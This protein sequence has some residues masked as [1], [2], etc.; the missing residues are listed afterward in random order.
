[1]TDQRKLAAVMFTDIV[2]YTALMSKDERQALKILQ[3]NRDLQKSLAE[4]HN[5]EFLKEMGD[6]TLLCFQSALDAVRCAMEIQKSVQD[7]SDLN[8]RIGIHLGDIVFKEGDVF[9]DGVNVASRIERLAEAGCICISEEV[10]R[11]VRNQPEIK[12]QYIGKR[13]LKNVKI[14]VKIYTI[15]GKGISVT[16]KKVVK[17]TQKRNSV[18]IAIGIIFIV[19]PLLILVYTISKRPDKR[20]KSI[21]VLPFEIKSDDPETEYLGEGIAIGVCNRL[22]Q[23]SD[24]EKV[25]SSSTLRNYKGKNVDAK[26]VAKEVKVKAVLFGDIILL[27]NNMAINVELKD[28]EDNSTLWGRRYTRSN[29]SGFEIEALLAKEIVDNLGFKL[30]GEDQHRLTRI[31]SDNMEIY[32]LYLRGCFFSNKHT[33]T[34]FMEGIEYFK[35]A[36]RLDSTYAPAFVGLAHAYKELARL[37]YISRNEAYQKAKAAIMRALEIDETLGEAHAT[38]GSILINFDW[39]LEK[40]EQEFQRALQLSPGSSI[41]HLLYSQYLMWIGQYDEAINH[42]KKAVDLDPLSSINS[43][44]LAGHYFYARRYDESIE[45]LRNNLKMNP[46]FIWSYNYLAYNYELKGMVENAAACAD[47]ALILW[48][49]TDDPI[50]L[51]TLG[52]VYAKTGRIKKARLSLEKLQEVSQKQSIDPMMFVHIYNGLGNRDKAFEYLQKAYEIRSGT[53]I[54]LN[55]YSKNQLRDIGSDDRYKTLLKK[56]GFKGY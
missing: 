38:L 16:T 15:I 30:S 4:K 31:H 51:G 33:E 10:Y 32:N 42:C 26:A 6:G 44:W 35:R 39:D 5:G 49:D 55:A 53:F 40:P 3:K 50:A 28:A 54:Y 19:I 21:A 1:M 13:N 24:L 12:T 48:G 52:E 27:H 20:I 25:I 47:T 22:A 34:G 9:G 18:S 43:Q 45:Q 14:P 23:L 36:I 37:S 17:R 2:G 41:V 56:M 7:D 8:L 29:E 46:N 11:S